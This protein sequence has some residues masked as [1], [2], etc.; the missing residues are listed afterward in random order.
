MALLFA[1]PARR[2]QRRS[3]GSQQRGQSGSPGGQ[4]CWVAAGTA[5]GDPRVAASEREGPRP[6][7]TARL[8]DIFPARAQRSRVSGAGGQNRYWENERPFGVPDFN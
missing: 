5:G 3:R 8:R 7:V 6:I 2:L 4:R 1:G